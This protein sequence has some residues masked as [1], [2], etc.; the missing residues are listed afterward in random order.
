MTFIR[1]KLV[2]KPLPLP[3]KE[4]VKLPANLRLQITDANKYQLTDSGL[5]A[6]KDGILVVGDVQ[7]LKLD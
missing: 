6:V 1:F 7:K 3:T 2:P 4:P 5:K